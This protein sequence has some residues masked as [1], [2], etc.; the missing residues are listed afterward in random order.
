MDDSPAARGIRALAK[1]GCRYN[2]G[3]IRDFFDHLLWDLR[4]KLFE[5]EQPGNLSRVNP[6]LVEVLGRF[7]RRYGCFGLTPTL[8]NPADTDRQTADATAREVR[9]HYARAL[10]ALEAAR[11]FLEEALAVADADLRRGIPAITADG[12]TE[13]EW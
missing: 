4:A 7:I 13:N 2:R 10:A 12:G 11:P 3:M 5:L 9:D 6:E 8:V 1:K